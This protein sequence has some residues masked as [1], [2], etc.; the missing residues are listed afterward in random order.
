MILPLVILCVVGVFL[1]LEFLIK[2]RALKCVSQIISL[3]FIAGASFRGGALFGG[4]VTRSDVVVQVVSCLDAAQSSIGTNS[5]DYALTKLRILREE[6]PRLIRKEIGE[7]V[8]L[9]KLSK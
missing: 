2:S 7:Q 3:I 4:D 9:E 6:M 8:L 5:N 1:L